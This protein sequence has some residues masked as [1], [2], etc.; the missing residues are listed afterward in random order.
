[1]IEIKNFELCQESNKGYGGHSGSKKGI[2]MDGTRWLLKYP[3]STKSM[4]VEGLS[5]TT[6]PLSEYLGSHI[7]EIVGIDTHKTMLGVAN[8]KL[9]VACQDFLKRGEE[10]VDFNAIRNN[11]NENMEKY[12]EERKSSQFNRSENLEDV[13]YIT[14]HNQYF[15][16]VPELKE[17]FWDMFVMDAFISNNDRNEAN[18]GLIYNEDTETLRLAPVYDNGASFY[19]KSNDEKLNSLLQDEFKFKQMAYDS[20]IS[21]FSLD[22]KE[23]NPLKYIESMENKDCNQ[24]IMR[25]VPKIDMEQIKKLFDEVPSSYHDLIVFTDLQKETYYKMLDYKLE[26]VLKVV[27]QKLIERNK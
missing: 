6:T 25:L 26:K 24:A 7:Y 15:K 19:G 4:N 18:W 12:L 14:E 13:I 21:I 3:K 8:G 5:Y 11:Y 16:K 22:G 1:M 17:R 20:C 9:V 10:I 27:Y 23:M 2:L